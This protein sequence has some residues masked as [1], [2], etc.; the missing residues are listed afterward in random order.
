MYLSD[1]SM[2]P[3]T[4]TP[5]TAWID[6]GLKALAYGGPDAVRVDRL[7]KSLSVTRGSFYA[8]FASRQALLDAIL[9]RW[10]R[11]SVD[12]VLKRVEEGGGDARAKARRAGVLTFSEELLP[13]DLAIRDWARRDAA[14][15]ERL[16]LVDNRR[17]DFLR[18]QFATI[19][20]DDEDI[21]ARSVLAFSLLIGN[22]FMAADHGSRTREE[23]LEIA[24]K[25][26]LG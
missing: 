10:E 17:M 14:V 4:R 1:Y 12:E 25:H 22:Y 3:P 11:A 8:Q 5:P 26:L 16:R 24:A 19:C 9:D 6:A 13:I 2:A 15:A 7:A 18:R 20:D 21:E 23:V